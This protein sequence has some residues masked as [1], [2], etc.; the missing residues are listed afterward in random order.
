MSASGLGG[1]AGFVGRTLP[2][3]KTIDFSEP[4]AISECQDDGHYTK[5]KLVRTW[6][7]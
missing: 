3:R 5:L 2:F 4:K 7:I 6:Q 1:T